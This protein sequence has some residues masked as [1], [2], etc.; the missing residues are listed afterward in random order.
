MTRAHVLWVSTSLATRGGVTTSVRRMRDTPLWDRW[1]IRHVGTHREGSAP[2]KIGY[3]GQA[4]VRLAGEFVLRRPAAVHIHMSSRGSFIRKA[5][6]AW[7]AR[8]LRIPIVL[9]LHSGRFHEF[10]AG[11]PAPFRRVIVAT[12]TAADTVIVLSEGWRERLRAIAPRAHFVVVPNAVPVPAAPAAR[13]S[14]P[15]HVVFLGKI[16]D[17]KGT[18]TLLESWRSALAA[19][20]SPPDGAD[21]GHR[22]T[23][24]GNGE[25]ERARKTVA[26]LGLAD[27]VTVHDWVSPE[28]AQALLADADVLALP[29]LNEGQP[30]VILEAMALGVTPLASRVG[31]IPEMVSDAS[32][33]VLVPP[34]DG[35]ALTAALVSL[36]ADPAL[37]YRLGD[38]AHR[39]ALAETDVERVWRQIDDLYTSVVTAR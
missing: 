3:F 2:L 1:R 18:F 34:A 30:M 33:G 8:A 26:D 21:T 27:S 9:H 7:L 31:G 35:A 10:H 15:A 17:K 4:I 38:A 20:P 32:E 11:S 16:W 28:E 19:L 5:A 12:L 13:R 22:L 37:R 36:L 25:V 24:A 23:I 6:V 14:G 29:S 39:R